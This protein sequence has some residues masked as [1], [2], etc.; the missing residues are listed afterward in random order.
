MGAGT[1]VLDEAGGLEILVIRGRFT[2]RDEVFEEQSWLRLPSHGQSTPEDRARVSGSNAGIL[3]KCRRGRG[4]ETSLRFTGQ[5]TSLATPSWTY[6]RAEQSRCG[7]H[8]SP[9]TRIAV[10]Q[11]RLT[12]GGPRL[13]GLGVAD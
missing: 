12:Q 7:S 6:Q 8:F 5:P 9:V 10:R 4:E 11:G 1:I 2:E 3:P 13:A